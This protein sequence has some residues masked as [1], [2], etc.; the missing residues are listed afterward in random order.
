AHPGRDGGRHRQETANVSQQ[1]VRTRAVA[2]GHDV[3]A[4]G[5]DRENGHLTAR[6][7]RNRGGGGRRAWGGGGGRDREIHVGGELGD[8]EDRRAGVAV[9]RSGP[10]CLR[11]G[12]REPVV[13]CVRAVWVRD[14]CE[15]LLRPAFR[16]VEQPF[17]AGLDLRRRA[18][19]GVAE[20]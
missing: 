13:G 10:V 15:N 9:T 18:L 2:R 5:R 3:R 20:L 11:E 17:P 6:H 7:G 8:V 12:N 1:L 4:E 16:H 19:A 14:T